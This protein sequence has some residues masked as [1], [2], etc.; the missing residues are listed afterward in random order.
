HVSAPRRVRVV[1]VERLE[2]DLPSRRVF[3]RE[4]C[5]RQVRRL[6]RKRAL[7]DGALGVAELR[8][9]VRRPPSSAALGTA[10]GTLA[11][12]FLPP[13][14]PARSAAR[15]MAGIRFAL[16]TLHT[17]TCALLGG[18]HRSLPSPHAGTIV[19]LPRGSGAVRASGPAM[20]VEATAI[21]TNMAQSVGVRS[22]SS[23]PML[24]TIS[25][26]SPRA[27]ISAPI[28]NASRAPTPLIRAA[29]AQAPNFVAGATRT[30][31]PHTAQSTSVD[32]RV[33][34][35]RN[36]ANAK[37]SGTTSLTP[38]APRARAKRRRTDAARSR[39]TATVR[40][41]A[42]RSSRRRPAADR[43]AETDGRQCARPRRRSTNGARPTS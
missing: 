18:P 37:N 14:L 26:I 38:I 12:N 32:N 39:Q 8:A 4:Q 21:N 43:A 7:G 10:V 3:A 30:T 15:A 34:S 28:V 42:P 27:F 29:A 33:T 36:P 16:R 6:G 20:H 22:P 31:A 17:K 40:A 13:L 1:R 9:F 25:S 11:G 2:I 41:A 5:A 24:R 23:S 19:L 35:V